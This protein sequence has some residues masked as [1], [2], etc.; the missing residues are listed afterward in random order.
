[1]SN[2][3]KRIVMV[4]GGS[5]G[6][7]RAICLAFAGPDT[8]V[9]FNYNAADSA[10][11]ETARLIEAAGGTASFE[12]V[13][14]VSAEQVG[15]FV[16]K[17][18]REHGG[19]HVLVN[20]AGITR[21]GLVVMMKEQD[22]DDVIQTNLKGAFN[23]IK[24]VTRPMMKQRYGRIVNITSVVGTTGNPGQANYAASKAG[25]IGLT[26][27]VAK[28][29]ASRNITANAVAP[30]FV[31]TDMTAG[32]PEKAKEAML[33]MIPLGRAGAP[34]EIAG[35][36]EFLAS[37]KAAYITGQVIHISGGMI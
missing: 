28:E 36:T 34:E 17:I 10:A 33:A 12:Q 13:D 29:L 37:D 35:L 9:C 25:I 18:V 6:L 32:L 7:G 19:V 4:T 2:P 26:K 3:E 22:W 23:C 1:M 14:V 21:D 31:E 30:G 15:G 16:K 11:R 27:S 20:N 8:H 24:A 5:R